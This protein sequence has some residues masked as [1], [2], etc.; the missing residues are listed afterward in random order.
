MISQSESACGLMFLLIEFF[1]NK[2]F[3]YQEYFGHFGYHDNILI[4]RR[5]TKGRQFLLL[6]HLI[7]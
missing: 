5:L 2:I 3:L 4:L 6:P 7:Y 1:K